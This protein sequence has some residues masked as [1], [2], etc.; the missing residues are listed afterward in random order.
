MPK[1]SLSKHYDVFISYRRENGDGQARSIKNA[2][3]KRGLRAYLDVDDYK[4]QFFDRKLLER[5]AE[6]PNFIVVL[7]PNSLDRCNQKGDWLRQEIACAI[8][9][10]RHIVPV[11]LPK[12]TFPSVNELPEEIQ[13]LP[14]YDAAPYVHEVFDGSMEK[15]F[16]MMQVKERPFWTRRA[17]LFPLAATLVIG[18]PVYFVMQYNRTASLQRAKQE[19]ALQ[20]M[21]AMQKRQQEES[22]LMG[23]ARAAELRND[24]PRAKDDYEKVV[25]LNGDRRVEA[26]ASLDA[27]KLKLSGATD[28]E[29]ALKDF[30]SG[31]AAFRRG[32]YTLAKT[33]FDQ[34][35]ARSPQN[36]PQRAQ[37]TDYARQTANRIQQQQHVRQAQSYFSAKNYSAAQDEAK[38]AIDTKDPDSS[39]TRQAQDLIARIPSTSASSVVPNQPSPEIQGLI[40]D[41]EG[42]TGQGHFK[43]ASNKAA[44]IEQLKGDASTLR[45][46]I[47]TAEDNRFQELISR[48]VSVNKQNRSELRDLLGAFQEFLSNAVNREA[49]ARRYV[50]RI[51]G[52]IAALDTSS[53][54]PPAVKTDS[55]VTAANDAAV[56]QQRLNEYAEAV[57]SSDLEKVKAVRQLKGNEEKKLIES[58]KVT[59]GKGYALRNCSS[60]EV[61]GENATVS[62][63]MVLTGS[64]ETPPGHVTF[65]LKR[66]YGQWYILSSN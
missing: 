57:A 41:A 37:A 65:F 44:A 27:V 5:I 24:L 4:K 46:T 16:R 49:D 7:S 29:I 43:E 13:T 28:S 25:E 63:D 52:E 17:F 12:F 58:L 50:D 48:Y 61:T 45:Q 38:Q 47:R 36:W 40:H 23:E 42:L 15:L 33:Q 31:V 56:I 35:L 9:T 39:L 14:R 64:K 6:A 20:Q 55:I 3:E 51:T 26:S 54:N 2:L 60:A 22:F 53:V 21:E 10:K 32:E 62:C 59:K 8:R 66:I 30:A 34:V 19:L 1:A 11:T 18:T